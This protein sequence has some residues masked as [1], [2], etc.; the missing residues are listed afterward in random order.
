MPVFA[1]NPF[2]FASA[3]ELAMRQ[4]GS[5]YDGTG[6]AASV[7]IAIFACFCAFEMARRREQG[8]YW[9]ALGAVMLGLGIWSMH[10]I[11]M[12]SFRLNCSVAYDPWLTLLSALPGVAAAAIALRATA[13]PRIGHLKLLLA[14]VVMGGGVGLMH[15]TGMAAF[16]F[17]GRL[18]YEPREFAFSLLAAVVTA[19]LALLLNR[20]IAASGLRRV[21]YLASLAAAVVLGLAISSMHYIAMESAR[22]LP[23]EGVAITSSISQTMLGLLAGCAT[24]MLL[25]FG[26]LYVFLY[27]KTLSA[28]TRYESILSTTQQGFVLIDE[29]GHIV[30]TNAA[31]VALLKQPSGQILGK[32]LADVLDHVRQDVHGAYQLQ[33]N[34]RC[35]DGSLLPCMAYV[36]T[37]VDSSDGRQISFALFSDISKR[38]A[39]EARAHARE[40]QFR[41]LLNSTP[42]PMVITNAEGRIVMVNLQ[43]EA[44]FGYAHTEF[45]GQPVEMLI[46]AA[47][48]E[49][50]GQMRHEYMQHAAPRRVGSDGMLFARTSKGSEIPVEVS[51]SPIVTAEGLLIASSLRDVTER[52]RIESA[53][54]AAN[55]EQEAILGTAS[56]GIALLRQRV[57]RQCNHGLDELFG[58]AVGELQGQPTRVW[59]HSQDDYDRVG[60]VGYAQIQSGKPY[61]LDLQFERKDGSLFWARTV[62]RAIDQQQPEKGVVLIV[63]DITAERHAQAQI[64][65]ANDEQRAILDTATSGI[66]LIRERTLHRCN[67]RLH[68]MFGWPLWEMVGQQT[69]I[70]Y[71]DDEANRIGGLPYE[72][73]WSGQPHVREQQLMRMDGS[74]FWARL[75]GNA[76]D[77]AD[78]SKGTVWII[79]D[80]TADRELSDA[81]RMAKEKAESATRAKSDFLSNMSHEIRTPMNAIIGMSR[82]ALQTE[83]DRKQRNY[84]EK[85]VQAGTNLLGIINDILDFSKIEAGKLSMERIDFRLEDVVDNL[86]NLLSMKT[87]EKGLELIFD[88]SANV[89]TALV[90]DPLRLGQVLTNLGNNAVKF[91]EK[92]EIVVGVSCVRQEADEVE[93]HFWVR[94]TGIGM[95]PEQTGRMFQSFTQA[96]SSTTRK[97]GGTGLGLAISKTLVEMMRGRIWV[98]SQAGQGSVF[99]FTARFGLQS[100]LQVNRMFTADEL[101]GIRLLVVDDNAAAREILHDMAQS[102]GLHAATASGGRQA[103]EMVAAA[104]AEGAPFDLL[105][106]DWRMPEMDG[107][108]LV[109]ELQR[110]TRLHAPA[111]IMVTAYGRE[112]ALAAARAQQVELSTVLTKPATPSSLLEAIGESLKK[113]SLRRTPVAQLGQGVQEAMARLQGARVLLVED[114]DLN[115]EL[116][117]ELLSDAGLQVVVANNGREALDILAGDG[118]FDG[119]SMDCQMPVMDGYEATRIICRTPA[120]AQIPVI[121]MTAN[122]MAGDRELVLE[123]GMR[124]HIAKPLDVD[125]MFETMARWITPSGAAGTHVVP[126]RRA[127]P[128]TVSSVP[129]SLPGIDVAAGLATTMNSEKLYRKLLS[130]F[131]KNQSQFLLHFKAAQQSDDV[132]AAERCAHTL[133]GNAG[134]I[135]ARSLQQ[136]AA[137]LE[138]HCRAGAGAEQIDRAVQAVLAELELVLNSLRSMDS[139]ATDAAPEPP[140]AQVVDDAALLAACEQLLPMLE[141]GDP[142][143]GQLWEK[144]RELFRAAYPGHWARIEALLGDFDFEGAQQSL[145]LAMEARKTASGN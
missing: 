33:A 74:L 52:L 143:A 88:A 20:R 34:L 95:T 105:L 138:Q 116:A 40:E 39:A 118:A 132:R 127:Y 113:F 126:T 7:T 66:A 35:S 76:V 61:K 47:L 12:S 26:L 43:A 91:T 99:H 31:M 14:G 83:L 8:R 111:V 17:Q 92:G 100:S 49:L 104:Q 97:Y 68:E 13:S 142:E 96:D 121:A 58:Y 119:I 32:Q 29:T 101:R 141:D 128:N 129:A 117:L 71:A 64:Q 134:N 139:A 42:D 45:I 63:W 135:G 1:G 51:L 59:F 130:K 16:Q 56:V 82:L 77:P 131:E 81:L 80:I 28:R 140:A 70:W 25:C 107:V 94:D 72:T 85:V 110:S 5:S 102:F 67:R 53:L 84:I 125:A 79:D 136:H 55:Q 73:I 21:P 30:Q 46:P 137:L 11:G 57:I 75:Q 90:G 6:I 145:R 65:L 103:L 60:S 115:Q 19:T 122:A 2:S 106:S 86:G 133:R 89:P 98:E 114:N 18:L 36:N 120:L 123:A 37:L 69:S 22:F 41:A 124:D 109:G 10:F 50:H 62:T 27:S 144:Q 4:I 15:Y 87:D 93:L 78:R 24:L 44:F 112:E 9:L 54:V 48:T 3:A 108:Q 23:L 38:V